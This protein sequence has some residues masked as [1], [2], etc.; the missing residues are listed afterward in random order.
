MAPFRQAFTGTSECDCARHFLRF[1]TVLYTLQYTFQG[2]AVLYRRLTLIVRITYNDLWERA[3]LS[4]LGTLFG[5]SNES[6]GR[7]R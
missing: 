6:W 3:I 4:G 2:T 5:G 7:R 1:V